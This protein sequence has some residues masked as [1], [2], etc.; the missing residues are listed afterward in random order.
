MQASREK[1]KDRL[2]CE[3]SGDWRS[4][5]AKLE[6]PGYGGKASPDWGASKRW[7]ADLLG[8]PWDDPVH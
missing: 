1:R 4:R 2:N 3:E 6:G 8:A 5:Q 7:V